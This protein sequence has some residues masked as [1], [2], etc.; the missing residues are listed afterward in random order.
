VGR[1]TSATFSPA[2][3]SPLFLGRVRAS[4]TSAGTALATTCGGV[5]VTMTVV[6]LPVATT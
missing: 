4:M 5:S 1:I 6:E 2:L 3:Q